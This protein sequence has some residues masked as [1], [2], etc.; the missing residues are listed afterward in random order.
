MR[1]FVYGEPRDVA[2]AGFPDYLDPATTAVISIDMHRG[3]LDDSPDC[4]APPR[5]PARSWT[6]STASTTRPAH[7]A[8]AWCT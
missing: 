2:P 4:P 7:A 5:A 3:H 8:C 1:A 6:A